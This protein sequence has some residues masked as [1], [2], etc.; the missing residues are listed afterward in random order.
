ME[1]VDVI[2]IVC[3]EVRCGQE[4]GDRAA[5]GIVRCDDAIVAFQLAIVVFDQVHDGTRF[6]YVLVVPKSIRARY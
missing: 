3:G 4:V 6:L 2:Y 5:L 1:A